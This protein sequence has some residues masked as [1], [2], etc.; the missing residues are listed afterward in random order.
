MLN[1]CG[2]LLIDTHAFSQKF[3][4]K[5][6]PNTIDQKLSVEFFAKTKN[7]RHSLL[8]S[9]D[10]LDIVGIKHFNKELDLQ[11]FLEEDTLR[12]IGSSKQ[13]GVGLGEF[14]N[15]YDYTP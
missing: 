11:L 14:V 13:Y 3:N 8:W 7:T 6:K 2:V 10:E 9:C 12:Y 15:I 4:Q 1:N 5:L